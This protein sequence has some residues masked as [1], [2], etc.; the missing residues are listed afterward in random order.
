M[1]VVP[2]P[3]RNDVCAPEFCS[4]HI[5]RHLTGLADKHGPDGLDFRPAALTYLKDLIK[6]SRA[7]EEV[8]LTKTGKGRDC[9]HRLSALQDHLIT[10]LYEFAS[11]IVYAASNPSTSERIAPVAVGGYA[12]RALAPGSDIALL[13]LLPFKQTARGESVVR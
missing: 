1:P 10:A 13:F 3:A 5:L 4:D 2:L 11:S 7:Q 8:R 9:A 12:R 6:T